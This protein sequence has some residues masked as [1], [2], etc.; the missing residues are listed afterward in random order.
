MS[1]PD[2]NTHH[3]IW[4]CTELLAFDPSR[5]DYLTGLFELRDMEYELN[6]NNLTCSSLSEVV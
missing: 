4:Y 6:Q 3:Y 1:N 2:I 5:V